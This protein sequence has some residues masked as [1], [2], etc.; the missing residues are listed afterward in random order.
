MKYD[1][2]NPEHFKKLERQAYD[3]TIDVTGFPPAAYRYFDRLRLLYYRYKY[4]GLSKSQAESEKKK[5]VAE[6]KEA[7]SAYENW[8][9]VYKEHQDNIRKSEMMMSDIEK[10]TSVNEIA[11]KACNIIAILTGE[12][13]FGKRQATKIKGACKNDR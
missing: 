5:L 13:S 2:N 8:C 10:T 4:D 9:A 3:G 7:V 11:V 12:S 1:F 6:Y